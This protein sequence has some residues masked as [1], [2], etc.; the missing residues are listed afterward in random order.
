[1]NIFKII[2]T[3]F[4]ISKAAGKFPVT[5]IKAGIQSTE[6]WVGLAAAVIMFVNDYFELGLSED[7][8]NNMIMLALAYIGGRSVV[9][10]ADALTNVTG[11]DASEK[12]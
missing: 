11:S 8:I 10:G 12:K 4:S 1:M 3:I 6:F 9:K 2:K 5:T 7:A